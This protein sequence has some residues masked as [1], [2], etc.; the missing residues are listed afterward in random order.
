M[1]FERVDEFESFES[2]VLNKS[3]LTTTD[4]TYLKSFGCSLL[5]KTASIVMFRAIEPFPIIGNGVASYNDM[6]DACPCPDET[7]GRPPR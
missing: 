5:T 6:L 7:C 2:L 3:W 4:K 1:I